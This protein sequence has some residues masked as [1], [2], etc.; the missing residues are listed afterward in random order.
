MSRLTLKWFEYKTENIIPQGINFELFRCFKMLPVIVGF[1]LLL[2]C[3]ALPGEFISLDT[4]SEHVISEAQFALGE[5]KK[6][7]DSTIYSTLSLARIVSAREND[8][9]FHRNLVLDVEISSPFFK[10]GQAKESFEMIV[11]THKED[12]VR[13][14][15]IDEF[16]DM[17]EQAIE[18]FWIANTEKKKKVR[19]E[20]FRRLEIESLLLGEDPG[21][22]SLP[23]KAKLDQNSVYDLLSVLDSDEF[24]EKR[25]NESAKFQRRISKNADLVAEE[26]A[27]AKLGLHELHQ[28]T[29]E[30]DHTSLYSE[31]QR[32]RAKMLLSS[33][34]QDL[35]NHYAAMDATSQTAK[36]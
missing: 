2:S 33:S 3:I 11:L 19:E 25:L 7:S 13:S 17:D 31:F 9:I 23:T 36:H 27:I 21:V 1:L 32:Y 14:F 8:G 12:G 26:R 35:H 22:D 4:A 34:M 18:Q 20:A 10:S 16:P 5:L 15:A 30:N 29:Q 28:I 6:L 24:L